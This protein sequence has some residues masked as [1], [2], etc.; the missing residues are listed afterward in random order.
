MRVRAQSVSE[1]SWRGAGEGPTH[2]VSKRVFRAMTAF[3]VPTPTVT[4]CSSRAT[5]WLLANNGGPGRLA[6][7]GERVSVASRRNSTQERSHLVRIPHL[8]EGAGL[9][10]NHT[11]PCLSDLLGEKMGFAASGEGQLERH[12]DSEDALRLRL[13]RNE[14]GHD[15]RAVHVDDEWGSALH[16]QTSVLN[17]SGST[18]EATNLSDLLKGATQFA[19]RLAEE[20]AAKRGDLGAHTLRT[21]GMYREVHRPRFLYDRTI[22]QLVQS[23]R[24]ERGTQ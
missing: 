15:V 1:R 18:S 16:I 24:R 22:L 14:R 17:Y 20:Q 11:Y 5:I 19:V 23:S 3:W 12:G 9:G 4:L 6:V 8:R 13:E 2:A 7:R 21:S 10:K